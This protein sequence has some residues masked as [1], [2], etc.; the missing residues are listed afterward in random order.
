MSFPVHTKLAMAGSTHKNLQKQILIKEFNCPLT[1]LLGRCNNEGGGALIS[2]IVRENR[3]K[4][5]SIMMQ[6][7]ENFSFFFGTLCDPGTILQ[8]LWHYP[9][10]PRYIGII[11]QANSSKFHSFSGTCLDLK[12][13]LSIKDSTNDTVTS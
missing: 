9:F 8:I 3:G 5:V 7:F 4:I 13:Q 10:G 11:I 6:L 1:T 12:S 2:S